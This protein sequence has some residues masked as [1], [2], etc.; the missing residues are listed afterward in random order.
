VAGPAG[1]GQRA[2]GRGGGEGGLVGAGGV[3]ALRG[4]EGG[5][6]Y[7]GGYGGGEGGGERVGA[8][9]GFPGGGG[10]L[11]GVGLWV[12]LIFSLVVCFARLV[13][14]FLFFVFP[15]SFFFLL[16]AVPCP[17]GLA[18]LGG[19]CREPRAL[20]PLSVFRLRRR[21]P[22]FPFPSCGAVFSRGCALPRSSPF[23]LL[24]FAAHGCALL[25][26]CDSLVRLC[27]SG[28]VRPLS[29]Y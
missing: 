23:F 27:L 16:C 18:L 25:R 19:Q 26:I 21:A 2:G 11:A 15:L 12:A 28:A 22:L 5:F 13:F 7:P 14:L 10:A 8:L 29:I 3:A 6:V 1:L 20:T 17:L 4:F 9:G 24:C